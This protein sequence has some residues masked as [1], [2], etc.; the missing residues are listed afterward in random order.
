MFAGDEEG[1]PV[2]NVTEKVSGTK[3][4]VFNPQITGRHR[5]EKGA[6]QRPFLS[7]AIFTGKDIGD[8][9]LGGLID[10]S[11]PKIRIS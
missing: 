2:V 1:P 8:Q 4:A 7:M 3:I 11:V 9:A 6:E 10:L 5:V